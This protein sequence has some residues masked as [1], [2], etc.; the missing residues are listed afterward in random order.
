MER[1]SD[2]IY[3]GFLVSIPIF[4]IVPY[5]NTNDAA[6]NTKDDKYINGFLNFIFSFFLSAASKSIILYLEI[7]NA[8]NIITSKNIIPK[9]NI[10]LPTA[11]IET[12]NLYS[13][14]ETSNNFNV[15]AD[16]T[17]DAPIPNIRPAIKDITATI[18]VSV[19]KI[20]DIFLFP[21]PKVIYM[22][23]SFLRFFIKKLFAYN[24]KLPNITDTNTDTP[25]ISSVILDI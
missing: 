12:V 23:N 6:L 15:K 8:L 16:K 19:T 21:I 2:G 4:S 1:I 13:F 14:M 24:I 3:I 22:P 20:L 10:V 11:L 9:Y 25:D 7:T 5:A 17:C 18:E